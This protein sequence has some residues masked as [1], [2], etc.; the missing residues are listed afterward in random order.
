MD[1]FD[2]IDKKKKTKKDK[3]KKKKAKK[4]EN[5]EKLEETVQTLD[6]NDKSNGW[7][8]EDEELE[9][10]NQSAPIITS[11]ITLQD[12]NDKKNVVKKVDEDGDNQVENNEV[13]VGWGM[14]RPAEKETNSDD[15]NKEEDK[16][17]EAPKP[18]GG[19]F[20]PSFKRQQMGMGSSLNRPNGMN[21]EL[22]MGYR[23]QR[24]PPEINDNMQFPT[25]QAA[26]QDPGKKEGFTSVAN[27]NLTSQNRSNT[28]QSLSTSNKFTAFA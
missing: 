23:R 28:N 18:T 6:L 9:Q 17:A 27:Q 15:E 3:T 7:V 13:Q 1:F 2:Q 20:I 14:T 5:D 11:N 8:N 22:R 4:P 21:P 16:Q 25:L 26:S 12:K 24:A 19:K 10:I